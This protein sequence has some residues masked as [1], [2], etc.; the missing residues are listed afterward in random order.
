[1]YNFFSR[2][3]VDVFSE[4]LSVLSREFCDIIYPTR[5]KT[6]EHNGDN[7][8]FSLVFESITA[9][10]KVTRAILYHNVAIVKQPISYDDRESYMDVNIT[11][12]DSVRS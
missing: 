5:L 3:N 12:V 9:S 1:V 11:L 4:N 7:E 2:A 10:Y 6:S 8:C